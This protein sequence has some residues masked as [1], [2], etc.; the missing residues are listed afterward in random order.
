M[1][2]GPAVAIGSYETTCLGSPDGRPGR[3]GSPR[4]TGPWERTT[5]DFPHGQRT[6]LD[7]LVWRGYRRSYTPEGSG[8]LSGGSIRVRGQALSAVIGPGGRHMR[9]VCTRPVSAPPRHPHGTELPRPPAPARPC[10]V[11]CRTPV[12]LVHRSE[13]RSQIKQAPEP[14]PKRPRD[15]IHSLY[16]PREVQSVRRTGGAGRGTA[17]GIGALDGVPH[18]VRLLYAAGV[19]AT[20]KHHAHRP[21]TNRRNTIKPEDQTRREQRGFGS[22]VGRRTW[23]AP[24]G[25]MHPQPPP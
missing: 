23:R 8:T 12:V 16:L 5:P 25:R 22:L 17:I 11:R 19:P 21:N 1:L 13:G 3:M 6:C 24:R 2:R 4:T 10:T 7:G 14:A 9:A 15:L 18:A 20:R